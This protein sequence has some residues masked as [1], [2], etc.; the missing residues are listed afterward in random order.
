MDYVDTLSA[1]RKLVAEEL[2][3]VRGEVRRITEL[4]GLKEAQ[5]RNLDDLLALEGRASPAA[6]SPA[7]RDAVG[8][9]FLDV[10][11]D[12]VRGSGSGVYYR[13]LLKALSDRGVAVPGQDPAANLIAHLTRDERFVRTGRGTYGLRNVHQATTRGARRRVIVRQ[14][15]KAGK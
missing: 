4:I 6:P 12:I 7:D 3:S 10:A 2:E 8:G 5:L 9:T 15:A 11:A 1:K 13:D 14:R